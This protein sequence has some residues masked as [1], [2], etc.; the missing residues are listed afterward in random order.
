MT[1]EAEKANQTR[2]DGGGSFEAGTGR[3]L[4]VTGVGMA[5]NVALMAIKVA[6]GIAAGSIALV[7][8]GVHSL[9]DLLTDVVVLVSTRIGSRPPDEDHPWGHGKMETMGALIIS[10]L[11]CVAGVEIARAAVASFTRGEGRFP[12]PFALGVAVFSFALKEWL[13]R[14][15]KREAGRTGSKALLV[16]AWHHRSDAFS[17]LAVTVGIGATFLGLAQGDNVAGV[18]VG[19]LIL[20]AGIRFILEALSELVEH[21]AD[22]AT[23]ARLEAAVAS[24]PETRGWHKI[25]SRYVGRVLYVDL[26]V[27]VP[28]HYT[29]VEADRIAHEVEEAIQ[30]SLSAPSN[31][32]VHVD[33]IPPETES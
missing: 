15:S 29:V 27:A 19:V 23:I 16:N 28:R 1:D 20:V 30:D 22:P 21:A 18:V 9:F 10:I 7:A 11:F 12:G 31:V 17:S 13:Y 8:D 5:V 26:H 24:L 4:R 14:I 25:R 32:I 3:I 33:P 6:A 2:P